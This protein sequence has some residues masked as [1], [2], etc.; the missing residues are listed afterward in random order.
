[1]LVIAVI[2]PVAT[3]PQAIQL[4]S[5]RD[6]EGLSFTTWATWTVLSG[7]WLWYGIKHNEPPIILANSI[8]LVLEGAIAVGILMYS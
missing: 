1:M 7:F 2:G 3:I 8:Y 6:A 5:T 4:F